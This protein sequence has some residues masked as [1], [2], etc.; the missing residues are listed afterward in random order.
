MSSSDHNMSVS[1]DED[2][3]TPSEAGD[4]SEKILI[5]SL[6]DLTLCV[7]PHLEQYQVCSRTV[8]RA[9]PV[10]MRM[11]NGNFVE[12]RP[13][14]GD[15]VINLPDDAIK[16]MKLFLNITHGNF[17]SVPQTLSTRDLYNLIVL[18]DKYDALEVIRP[19]AGAWVEGISDDL[20]QPALLYIARELG[21]AQLLQEALKAFAHGWQM[22]SRGELE[23]NPDF[24]Y[25]DPPPYEQLEP[26][27]VPGRGTM[28]R[29]MF[30]LNFMSMTLSEFEEMFM[31]AREALRKIEFGPYVDL[32][33]AVQREELGYAT[34]HNTDRYIDVSN[35]HVKDRH[36]KCRAHICFKILLKFRKAGLGIP[37]R[38]E[39]EASDRSHD[40]IR[41]SAAAINAEIGTLEC[42]ECRVWAQQYLKRKRESLEAA[43]F[44][45]Q[46]PLSYLVKQAVKTGLAVTKRKA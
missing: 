19:W 22:T 31:A 26:I 42:S 18:L 21:D 16:P 32:F 3:P 37:T 14:S 33:E 9:S 29:H 10:F 34:S 11:F 13:S 45:S 30:P 38:D 46:D 17:G 5:D 8:A 20:E 41:T 35:Q 4:N 7:G 1:D 23:Y 40:V 25:G 12:S 28:M 39:F 6:G 44:L 27:W 2:Y 43:G 24:V 36:F 15:W